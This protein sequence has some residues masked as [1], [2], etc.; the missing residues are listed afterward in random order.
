MYYY[1]F[2]YYFSYFHENVRGF[3]MYCVI[4]AMKFV[5]LKLKYKEQ[6]IIID[7][8]LNRIA[9]NISYDNAEKYLILVC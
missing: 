8:A 7:K 3:F 1:Y 5:C 9:L 4:L 6:F 2:C